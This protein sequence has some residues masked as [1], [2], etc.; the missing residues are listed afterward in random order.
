MYDQSKAVLL[1]LRVQGI[2]SFKWGYQSYI[3]G[4]SFYNK[5]KLISI[6]NKIEKPHFTM[7][8]HVTPLHFL[9]IYCHAVLDTLLIIH[10]TTR[11]I[12]KKLQ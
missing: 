3:C 5:K 12:N 1:Y 9:I 7:K 6:C 4:R 10:A 2:K 11:T 8:M